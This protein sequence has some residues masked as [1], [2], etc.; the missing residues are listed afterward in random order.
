MRLYRFFGNYTTALY[1]QRLFEKP[2]LKKLPL[3]ITIGVVGLLVG[4]YFLYQ[5][6]QRDPVRPW[7]LIPSDAI[8]VYEKDNCDACGDAV[9]Q[10]PLWRLVENAAFYKKPVDSIRGRV[11]KL[12]DSSRGVLVSAHVTKK[13]DF[14]LVYYLSSKSDVFSA[15]DISGMKNHTLRTRAFNGVSIHEVHFGKQIFSFTRIEDVSV[16]SFTPFLLEDVIRSYR[17]HENAGKQATFGSFQFTSIK[18]DA[19]NLYLRLEGIHD[20]LSVFIDGLDQN[21]SLGRS[22][23][24][25]VKADENSLTLNGFSTDSIDRSK[26]LL[27]VFKHQNPVSFGLKNLIS[28]RVAAVSAYGISD[29]ADFS[30]DLEQFIKT[31]RP[32]LRDSL[33]ALSSKYSLAIGNLYSKISDEV[34]VC[35]MEARR[36]T[37]FSKIVLIETSDV[38]PW[39]KMFGTLGERL[40]VDTVFYERYSQYEIREIPYYGFGEKFLW[41][42]VQGFK[43]NYYT[44][45]GNVLVIGEDV[46]ELKSY[47]G[48]IDAEE[49]WGRSV[50]Q[51]RFLEATLLESNLSLYV[52]A[53]RFWSV[54][55]SSLQPRWQGF[56]KDNR[57]LMAGLQ[58]SSIQFSHLNNSYYTNALFTFRQVK[59]AERAPKNTGNNVTSFEHGV[60]GMNTVRSHINRSNEVLVQDSLNELSLVGADGKVLWK[61]SLGD[62]IISDVTQVDFF[63]NGKLQYFFAT[64]TS[65]HVIDRLGNYVQPFPLSLG[66]VTVDHVSVIDYDNSKKYRFLVADKEGKIYMYDKEGNVLDG[67]SPNNAGGMLSAPPKHYRIKG[68]DY[69]IASR[70]DGVVNVWTRR[71]ELLRNFPLNIQAEPVGEIFLERGNS[72]DETYFVLVTR[73]GFRARVTPEGKLQSKETLLKT[74]VRSTFSLVNEKAEKS[75]LTVQQDERQVTVT[76]A[77]GRKIVSASVTGTTRGDVRYYDYGSGKI[78]ITIRDR[79]QGLFYVY[80]EQGDLLTTPPVE[81]PLLEIRPS[82]SDDFTLFFVHGRS[83][84][85]QPL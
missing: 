62:R 42:F 44:S 66:S 2:A 72:L 35:F 41:P 6:F 57:A 43:H 63:A 67:W 34:A 32:R 13:D 15:K 54:Y 45:V 31:K 29:G 26:Y 65:L 69:I 52:N 8:L 53:P 76:H 23:L 33:N 68:R 5:E 74:S 50:S 51:N 9:V 10:S 79:A 55:A 3:L 47:L 46:E 36:Q 85:I 83:L 78:F 30:K 58:M 71:G 25:D 84:V 14:D 28:N 37:G 22:A 16:G 20:L 75:Y 70:K 11:F 19:G 56:M 17:N 24:L 39:L 1:L 48:D 80:N 7:D 81:T 12:L 40:S 4:A 27:S 38:K 59:D 61:L 18:E 82:D 21:Y 77:D 73:D 49:T 60:I 64:P